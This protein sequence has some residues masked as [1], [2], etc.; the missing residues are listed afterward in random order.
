MIVKKDPN[1]LVGKPYHPIDYHCYSFIEECLDAPSLNGVAIETAKKSIDE[2]KPFFIVLD[3][4]IDYC[5]AL[6]GNTH[7]GIYFDGGIYHNDRVG[8]K[9]ETMRSIKRRLAKIEF[10]DKDVN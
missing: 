10:Y 1:E 8:V 9:Y 7:T 4:P 3:E 6:L 5:I 2:Y